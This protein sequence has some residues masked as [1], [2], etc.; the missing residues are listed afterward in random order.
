MKSKALGVIAIMG[1]VTAAHGQ[2]LAYRSLNTMIRD[3]QEQSLLPTF[4]SRNPL[5]PTG[6]PDPEAKPDRKLPDPEVDDKSFQILRG[7]L[8]QSHDEVRMTGGVEFMYHGYHVFSDVATGNLQTN[9]FTLQGNVKLIGK[10]AVVTGEQISVDFDKKIYH[11]V[12]SKAVLAPSLIQGSFLKDLYT[13]GQ[14]SYGSGNEQQI[15]NGGITS[16]ELLH[17]HYELN[18][19]NIIIRPGKRVI[20]RKAKLKLFGRTVLQIPYLS[21]PLDNRSYNN[22]PE[23]GQSQQ[24]GYFIKTRFGT[25]LHGNDDLYARLDYMSK[26]GVGIGADYLYKNSVVNGVLNVYTIIGPGEMLKITDQHQQK[27]K[28]GTLTL[29]TDHENNNY[30]VQPGSVLENEKALL[31]FPQGNNATTRL[32]A[33]YTGSSTSGLSTTSEALG[34]SDSRKFGSK[35][36]TTIDVNY[37]NSQSTFLGSTGSVSNTQET[38]N[39]RFDGQQELD[40]ATAELQ[41]QRQIPVGSTM[42]VFGSSDITP[43]LSLTSD[44]KRLVGEPFA[45]ALPFKTSVSIGQFSDEFGGSAVTRDSFDLRFQKP[46]RSTG[47]FHSELS[48][49]FR[50]GIYS[51]GTA[52]YLLNL[53]ETESYKVGRDASF[54]V[55]YNYLRPYGYSPVS[56]DQ[57]GQQNTATADFSVKASKT[58]TIGTQSG[59]D[60]LRLQQSEVAWQ[61]VGVRMEWQ[62]KDYLLFR[63][64]ATYDTFQGAWSN[65]R[66]DTSY[67]PGATFVSIGTYYDG[68]QHTFS[69]VN[70]FVD[71][72]TWGKTKVSAI[73]TY[74]GYTKQFDNQQY[75]LTYDLHCWEA[76]MTYQIQQTGFEPGRTITFMLRLKALPY[77]SPFGAGS[78]GQ[79]LGTGTGTSF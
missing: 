30:L 29:N 79:P 46:D 47:A 51:D 38:M 58:F 17:P 9:I 49:E 22:T 65:I 76:V 53:A 72:L 21:I 71:N 40:K 32:T 37:Q 54:N 45:S 18:G 31:T 67:K 3:L 5:E 16:C 57:T 55:H 26:L 61:P 66:L 6:F 10:D 24:E 70:A 25:P 8:Q 56:L 20:F 33:N 27:F 39:V 50:Q 68:I 75:S 12:D 59:Y 13:H 2:I 52:Q 23:V 15:L 74:D 63:S 48:G 43:E 34:V 35:T 60:L 36:T 4:N 73:L 1:S 41:Y 64:Q 7:D 77:S 28:W 69:N 19:E 11:A 44:A 78:R 14:Q 62:P 42:A